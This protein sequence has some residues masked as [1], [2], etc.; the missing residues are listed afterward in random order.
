M[1]IKTDYLWVLKIINDNKAEISLDLL[2]HKIEI[3][4]NKRFEM[5]TRG[6]FYSVI[7]TLKSEKYIITRKTKKIPTSLMIKITKE[8]QDMLK[9]FEIEK[10]EKN[11]ENK[12]IKKT[13]D[14]ELSP[15]QILELTKSLEQSQEQ[16]QELTRSLEQSKIEV[17]SLSQALEH[18]QSQIKSLKQSKSQKIT[19]K[20][21]HIEKEIEDLSKDE[22]KTKVTRVVVKIIDGVNMDEEDFSIEQKKKN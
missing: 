19:S 11:N 20:K 18:S 12:E 1:G 13:K 7:R 16:V 4:N 14:P 21:E 2:Y 10:T 6:S 22:L 17:K 9:I 8:A 3:L 15:D 5:W